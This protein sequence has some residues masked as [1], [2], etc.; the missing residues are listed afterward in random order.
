MKPIYKV[1]YGTDIFRCIE[2]LNEMNDEVQKSYG[3]TGV[4]FFS[5]T[6]PDYWEAVFFVPEENRLVIKR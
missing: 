1:I 4:Y 5:S 6:E 3:V 2:Q